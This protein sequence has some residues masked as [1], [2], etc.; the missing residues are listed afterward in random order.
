MSLADFITK[1]KRGETP[2]YRMLYAIGKRFRNFE[3]PYIRGLH[4]I[5]YQ[6]NRFRINTWR[7]FWRVVYH[8]PLFRSRCVECGKNLYLYHSGQGLPWIEGNLK[9]HV[10]SDVN[11]FDKATFIALTVGENPRLVIG[12]HTDIAQPITI[13]IGNEVEI[14]SHCLIGCTLI[15]DNPGHNMDYRKRFQKLHKIVIGRVKIGNYVWAGHQSMI[16][17]NVTVGDGAVIGVNTVVM[18]DVPP[19]CIVS[20]NPARIAKKLPFRK[21]MIEEFGEAQYNKYLEAKVEDQL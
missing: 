11:I 2:F 8:Q 16:I 17:G 10:G 21:D 3:I 4:D 19:F 7:S 6:E 9:I 1:I 15:S 5:L 12:D 14:G 18:N 20:G 13:M